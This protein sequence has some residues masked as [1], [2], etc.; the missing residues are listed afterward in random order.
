MEKHRLVRPICNVS[1]SF[2][3]HQYTF[4]LNSMLQVTANH[5]WSD[6]TQPHG[7]ED[8]LI[9]PNFV[10]LGAKS[11][12]LI[13]CILWHLSQPN[14]SDIFGDQA[15]WG[16]VPEGTKC[17][18]VGVLRV[19]RRDVWLHHTDEGKRRLQFRDGNGTQVDLPLTAV[20]DPVVTHCCPIE[21][22]LVLIG[23]ARPYAGDSINYE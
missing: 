12:E 19:Q 21:Y 18:S 1:Q 4:T 17:P 11:P 20:N 5:N 2:W 10:N 15:E 9:S 8:M 3:G 23:L 7:N 13:Y 22:V 16:F 6:Q 14:I